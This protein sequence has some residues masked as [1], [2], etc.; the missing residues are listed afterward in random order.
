M[1]CPYCIAQPP[2]GLGSFA[3]LQCCARLVLSARPNKVAAEAM[4]AV[5]ARHP[6]APGRDAILACVRRTLEKPP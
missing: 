5:I 3:C 4:L 1:T 6:D 2:S